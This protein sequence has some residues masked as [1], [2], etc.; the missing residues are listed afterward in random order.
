VVA[1]TVAV[2]EK[3]P[4]ASVVN[5]TA[6]TP[7]KSWVA[8]CTNAADIAKPVVSASHV[9]DTVVV[10]PGLTVVGL[11]ATPRSNAVEVLDASVVVGATVVVVVVVDDVLLVV[12]GARSAGASA[13]SPAAPAVSPSAATVATASLVR[14]DMV[15]S[16]RGAC[17]WLRSASAA[18]GDCVSL[19]HP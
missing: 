14:A 17:G 19:D 9:P 2:T 18:T 13:A 5:G 10:P 15:T 12:A 8:S 1:A 4:L 3:W 11:T 7:A 6:P 16:E